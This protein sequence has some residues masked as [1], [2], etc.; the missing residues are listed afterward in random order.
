MRTRRGIRH[1]RQWAAWHFSFCCCFN[2]IARRARIIAA[3]VNEWERYSRRKTDRQPNWV[4]VTTGDRIVKLPTKIYVSHFFLCRHS[5]TNWHPRN[6]RCQLNMY[7]VRFKVFEVYFFCPPFPFFLSPS[8]N[9][10]QREI[11]F[12]S[13]FRIL[14]NAHCSR[15][16]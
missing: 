2:Y 14:R 9:F 4:K 1:H 8:T 12:P 7:V 16:V 13:D 3:T 6:F 11:L 10:N 5:P 15:T